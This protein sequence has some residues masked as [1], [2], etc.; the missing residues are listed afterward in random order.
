VPTI[1]YR[2]QPWEFV[3][4]LVFERCPPGFELRRMSRDAALQE[5]QGLLADAEFLMGSW[6]TTTVTLTED[7]FRAAPHLKLVQLM[8][9][10]YEHIDLDLAARYGVPVAHFGGSNASVVAEHCIML[11]LALYRRLFQ[12]DSAVRDGSWRAGDPSLYELRGKRV[13]LIGLGY[14]GRELAVRLRAFDCELV[15]FARHPVAEAPARLIELHELLRTSDVVSLHVPI[16][17]ATR[18]LIG[19]RELALMAPQALLINT[20]RGGV[21]DERALLEALSAGRLAGAALDVFEH[22]P[23]DPGSPLLNLPHVICTPHI[24]GS[25]VEVWPRVVDTCFA[26]I[27]RVSRGEPPLHLA[28]KLD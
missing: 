24:A 20:S 10:G 12:L 1:V 25:S 13:G 26:N 28:R 27:Q 11:I 16:T 23:P 8:S 22:E 14:I 21:V 7:D 9:A 3:D 6:V 15:Y 18:G 19:A 17:R 5:R 2:L 4:R